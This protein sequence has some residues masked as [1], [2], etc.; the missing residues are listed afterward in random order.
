MSFGLMSS[1]FLRLL[2][3]LLKNINEFNKIKLVTSEFDFL[4]LRL[5]KM[6]L[7]KPNRINLGRFCG[8]A[9]YFELSNIQTGT[10]PLS[11]NAFATSSQ[12]KC[13]IPS[14]VVKG[15][16]IPFTFSSNITLG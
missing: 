11:E 10:K 13:F 15:D 8:I 4:A 16:I 12:A 6:S 9:K 14:S 1:K 3:T 5:S 7:R 2:R